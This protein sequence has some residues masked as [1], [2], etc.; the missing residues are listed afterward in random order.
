MFL[1]FQNMGWDYALFVRIECL[2][3][4]SRT[5]SRKECGCSLG[6]W[7]N[8][9]VNPKETQVN[10]KRRG[11]NYRRNSS[12]QGHILESSRQSH[13]SSW[14]DPANEIVPDANKGIELKTIVMIQRENNQFL[15]FLRL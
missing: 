9:A 12:D 14:S 2:E 8:L 6:N 3:Q 4:G 11:S 1:S 13:R 10:W 7:S 5:N 15:V